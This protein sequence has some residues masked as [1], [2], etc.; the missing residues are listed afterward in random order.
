MIRYVQYNFTLGGGG[1][2]TY[3]LL[4]HNIGECLLEKSMRPA[5]AN[6]FL[7]RQSCYVDQDTWPTRNIG[8][9]KIFPSHMICT[10]YRSGS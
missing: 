6:K 4:C 7:R 10:V 3:S 2:S 9:A 8:N 5:L 1:L